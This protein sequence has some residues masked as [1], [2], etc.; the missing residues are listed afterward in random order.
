M[1]PMSKIQM[2][3]STAPFQISV[4]GN[5]EANYGAGFNNSIHKEHFLEA[6]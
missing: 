2:T 6:P 5:L 3:F 4:V 1:F